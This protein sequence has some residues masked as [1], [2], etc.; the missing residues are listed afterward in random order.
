MI[1]RGGKEKAMNDLIDGMVKIAFLGTGLMGRP[2]A[3]RLLSAGCSLIA[4]NRTRKK[5][6]PLGEIGAQIADTSTAA[7]AGSNCVILMVADAGAIREVLFPTGT[8]HLDFAGKTIIQMGTIS[9]EQSLSLKAEV[10]GL[11]GEYLEAPVLGSI[12]EA[13]RGELFVMV[14]A[15]RD[16]FERWSAVF[17]CFAPNPLH[18]GP[19]GKAAAFKLA[20]NQLIASQLAAFSFSLG[21][22]KR[23]QIDINQFMDVL[24]KS[25]VYAP[26]FDNKLPRMLA[27]D[28]SNPTFLTKHLLKDVTLI[29]SEGKR[30]GLETRVLEELR[31]VVQKA[32][33]LGLADA[34]YSSVY[35][36][37]NPPS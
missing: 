10:E 7:I 28:F 11:R 9:P 22:V 23:N 37:F 16:L 21:I 32:V 18:V 14:G 34:D 4:Y 15:T 3:Q 13:E 2:M 12:K 33:N 27:R 29:I 36:E 5:A 17:K 31:Q 6:V 20:L 26:Q 24:R 30:V 25:S 8:P 19:V 35:N 1:H